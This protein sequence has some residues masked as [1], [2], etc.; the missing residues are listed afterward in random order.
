MTDLLLNRG[1]TTLDIRLLV[2]R[3]IV[4]AF[5]MGGRVVFSKVYAPALLMVPDTHVAL[6]AWGAPLTADVEVHSMGCGWT[7]D[8]Y[9][10]NPTMESLSTLA[11][12]DHQ[13]REE[14]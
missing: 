13:L 8:P 7:A 4:E 6:Q 5:V 14:Q 9:Q 10:T 11:T 12:T 2:D 3:S 1:E